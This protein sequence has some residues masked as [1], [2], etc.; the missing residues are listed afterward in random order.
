MKWDNLKEPPTKKNSSFIS[1]MHSLQGEIR[2]WEIISPPDCL[3]S[4]MWT[5]LQETQRFTLDDGFTEKHLCH[6]RCCGEEL[7]H[8]HGLLLLLL[9]PSPDWL[10]MFFYTKKQ[11]RGYL[12]DLGQLWYIS[13]SGVRE[14]GCYVKPPP[15][16]GMSGQISNSSSRFL[17]QECESFCSTKIFKVKF[18]R[19]DSRKRIIMSHHLFSFPARSLKPS[20]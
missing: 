12:R 2:I 4:L 8:C 11:W 3:I 7:E 18:I 5:G 16:Q 1:M 9:P 15:F 17:G 6:C 13:S 20:L 14:S 10:M 19:R